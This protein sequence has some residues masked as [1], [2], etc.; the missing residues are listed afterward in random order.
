MGLGLVQ[1]CAA[2]W[3]AQ[4]PGPA[5]RVHPYCQ[6]GCAYARHRQDGIPRV[7]GPC[8]LALEGIG[9]FVT[10]IAAACRGSAPGCLV[11]TLLLTCCRLY[12][13]C[14]CC[15]TCSLMAL[16]G[17]CCK[18]LAWVDVQLMACACAGGSTVMASSGPPGHRRP[19]GC[20][21]YRAATLLPLA[22]VHRCCL[23]AHKRTW[24]RLSGDC[25]AQAC[26]HWP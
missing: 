19:P 14:C 17:C 13:H 5:W 22:N 11:A 1:Q 10:L 25:S 8:R 6:D 3:E 2:A 26:V 16:V 9:R 4:V 21:C 18:P 7:R 12:A 15:A 23:R 24:T 20:N